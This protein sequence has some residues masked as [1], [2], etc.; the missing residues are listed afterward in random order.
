MNEWMVPVAVLRI[1]INIKKA[2]DHVDRAALLSELTRLVPPHVLLAYAYIFCS[3]ASLQWGECC[4]ANPI[5]ITRGCPQGDPS[6]PA[7]FAL[8][9]S[10]LLHPVYDQ[11]EAKGLSVCG[12]LALDTELLVLAILIYA[13]LLLLARSPDALE[14]QLRDVQAALGSA[15]LTINHAKSGLA[16]NATWRQKFG[17]QIFLEG[18]SLDATDHIQALGSIISMNGRWDLAVHHNLRKAQNALWKCTPQL[19]Q[20]KVPLFRRL[21]LLSSVVSATLLY[22]CES[23][24]LS[25]SLATQLERFHIQCILHMLRP[26]RRKVELWLDWH[27]RSV[28]LARHLRRRMKQQ[29]WLEKLLFRQHAWWAKSQTGTAVHAKVLQW[30]SLVWWRM[31]QQQGVRHPARFSPWRWESQLCIAREP[32]PS[33]ALW[34]TQPHVRA[35]LWVQERLRHW[36]LHDVIRWRQFT[37]LN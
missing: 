34:A 3:Q 15:G 19:R 1:D 29:P 33:L 11:W 6:S 5:R 4:S 36:E 31:A 10:A 23:W 28:H 2:Y 21:Q 27:R 7:L 37:L 22:G 32:F 25:K 8:L 9:T 18:L 17:G 20:K 35:A 13:D 26:R 30:R 12:D 24:I 16:C 14:Q